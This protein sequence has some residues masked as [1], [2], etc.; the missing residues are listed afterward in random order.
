[1]CSLAAVLTEGRGACDPVGWGRSG[2][3][4]VPMGPVTV[5][6]ERAWV[7]G[8]S[9]GVRPSGPTAPAQRVLGRPDS[10]L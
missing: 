8:Q 3:S 2:G 5:S 4:W 10:V 6:G 9:Q 1:M 7:S